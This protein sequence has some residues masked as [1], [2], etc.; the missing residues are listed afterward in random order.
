MPLSKAI[1]A[2]IE[3]SIWSLEAIDLPLQK[4]VLEDAEERPRCQR[5]AQGATR[6]GQSRHG[7]SIG[8]IVT[9]N[10]SDGDELM[11]GLSTANLRAMLCPVLGWI[12]MG[13]IP[14]CNECGVP[15][16]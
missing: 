15:F 16:V 11:A 8:I 3:K 4:A 7:K 2:Q 5:Y 1:D 10:D 14:C 13:K 9:F 6:A 12:P